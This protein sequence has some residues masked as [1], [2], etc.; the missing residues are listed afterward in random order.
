VAQ[1]R[2][3]EAIDTQVA[4]AFEGLR[5]RACKTQMDTSELTNAMKIQVQR[6]QLNS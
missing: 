2:E 6:G 3:E 4:R 1:V 5:K